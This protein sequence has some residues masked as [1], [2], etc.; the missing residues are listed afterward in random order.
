MELWLRVNKLKV[1]FFHSKKDGENY[2]VGDLIC[3]LECK[4]ELP[5]SISLRVQKFRKKQPFISFFCVKCKQKM[6]NSAIKTKLFQGIVIQEQWTDFLCVKKRPKNSF[7]MDIK[8]VPLSSPKNVESVFDA[9]TK[10]IDRE[11]VI[12]KT[13]IAGRETW[14]ESIVGDKK[15]E[16]EHET[17][18]E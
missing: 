18:K 13:R 17:E 1:A 3:C 11:E 12:D 7:L 6:L 2:Y 9:A 14:Q 4:K 16:L 5:I 10:T 15:Y 8:P